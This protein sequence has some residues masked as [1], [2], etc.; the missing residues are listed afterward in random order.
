MGEASP[1]TESRVQPTCSD[2]PFFD[3]RRQG[4][5][6]GQCR[7]GIPSTE[8]QTWPVVRHD[9][10]CAHHPERI[11]VADSE[12]VYQTVMERMEDEVE[13]ADLGPLLYHL[14]HSEMFYGGQ[15]A[16][17]GYL[18]AL[19]TDSGGFVVIQLP[20]RQDAVELVCV[21]DTLKRETPSD[22][23]AEGG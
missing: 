2:C 11:V 20:I 16:V 14:S 4:T 3:D 12:A 5:G 17:E 18:R 8:E 1:D 21:L 22:L 23:K 15:E 7:G 6:H 10:W 9:D 13:M 19:T